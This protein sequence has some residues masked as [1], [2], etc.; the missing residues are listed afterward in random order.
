MCLD[1]LFNIF[2][3]SCIRGGIIECKS[4]DKYA[5]TYH[6]FIVSPFQKTV[7]NPLK[8]TIC[9][10]HDSKNMVVADYGTGPG[11][12]LPFLSRRFKKVIALDFSAEMIKIA[13]KRHNKLT[14]ITFIHADMR[15]LSSKN[16]CVDVAVAVNSIILP[17]LKDVEK[18]LSEIYSTIKPKGRLFCVF[19]AMEAII[20][21]AMLVYEYY[22]DKYD[23][24]KK[25]LS[26]TRRL[27]GE[28]N[29]SFIRGMFDDKG[30]QQ[31]FFYRFEVRHRL[32][33]AGFKDVKI[34][35]ISYP[36][37]TQGDFKNFRG[38]PEMWDWFVTARK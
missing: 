10:L 30:E 3:L 31:K 24:K 29:F 38:K 16:L 14:N 23:N 34:K 17:D 8:K 1:N 12:L 19:P 4:W 25:A 35:K 32:E 26:L 28:K 2:S 37:G 5:E 18:S 21:H 15:D 33:N 20:H 36:W 22:F 13:K 9:S 11:D 6:E 7:N 27:I